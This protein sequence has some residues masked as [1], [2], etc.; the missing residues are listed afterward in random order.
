MGLLLSTKPVSTSAGSRQ[1][2][3]GRTWFVRGGSRFL[4]LGDL[5]QNPETTRL[6]IV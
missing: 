4:L 6:E 3:C 2:V 5:T 1:K